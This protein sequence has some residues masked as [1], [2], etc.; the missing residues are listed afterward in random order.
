MPRRIPE[1]SNTGAGK[2]DCSE[3]P[4]AVVLRPSTHGDRGPKDPFPIRSGC[5]NFL[6]GCCQSIRMHDRVSR[7]LQQRLKRRFFLHERCNFV[8][9]CLNQ[10]FQGTPYATSGCNLP[11]VAESTVQLSVRKR[12][13]QRV[14]LY[15][16]RPA[17]SAKDS[18]H[19][20]LR[21]KDMY[22]VDQS[23]VAEYQYEKVTIL[24]AGV[25]P[26]DV[27]AVLPVPLLPI[28]REP[29]T[30]ILRSEQELLERGSDDAIV[31]PYWDPVLVANS[32]ERRR[33][34]LRLHA[35]GLV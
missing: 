26:K 32:D 8:L 15:G 13:R 22:S 20:I 25:V 17:L 2:R 10:M 4:G 16:D 14:A 11:L 3:T 6:N 23:S 18:F 35:L 28:V 33:L 1:T 27:E 19:E 31:R 12:I 24:T 30:Y 29:E 34:I 9:E 7:S 21:S 5:D